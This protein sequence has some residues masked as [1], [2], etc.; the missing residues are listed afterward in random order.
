MQ[1]RNLLACT[2]LLVLGG[3]GGDVESMSDT[4]PQVPPPPPPAPAST[5]PPAIAEAEPADDAQTPRG[6]A[7]SPP[8]AG[9]DDADSSRKVAE[10]GVGRKSQQIEG[11]GYLPTVIRARFRAEERIN[12]TNAQYALKL[13]KAQHGRAPKTHDEYM[14]QIIK[15]NRINLPELPAGQRYVYDPET[16]Q[17]MVEETGEP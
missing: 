4:A 11:G 5:N 14:E 13:F 7:E 6:V 8:A 12:L 9:S 2:L 15:A 3:C 16:E 1:T 17:L 10:V